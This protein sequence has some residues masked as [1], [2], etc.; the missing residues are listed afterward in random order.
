ADMGIHSFADVLLH[1]PYRYEDLNLTS[2]GLYHDQQRLVLQGKI[3]STPS[4]FRRGSM[5]MTR[6][7]FKDQH[8]HLMHV[9]AFNRPFLSK[10]I[11]PGDTMMVVG[12]YDASRQILNLIHAFKE[13]TSDSVKLKPIYRLPSTI[14]NFVFIRLVKKALSML[15]T[16]T[17]PQHLPEDILKAFSLPDKKQSLK[18]IHLPEHLHE[19]EA[20]MQIFKYEEAFQ[21]TKTMMAIRSENEATIKERMMPI[22]TGAVI[23]MMENLPYELTK[24]QMQAVNDILQDM[25]GKRRMYRL[26]QGDVGSGKTVVAALALYA[27]ALRK[28]QGALMAPTDSLAKQHFKTL[29]ELLGQRGLTIRL[30]VGSLPTAD[31]KAI[32]ESLLNGTIDIV[33]GTHA[34]FSSDTE[35]FSLGL[36]VI[37]EQHRFG[38]NQRDLLKDKGTQA[39]LL[40][41]SATPIP[42]SLAMTVYADM[43]IS[44]LTQFP[45][46]G[47]KVKTKIVE[48]GD[49]L[50]DYAIKAALEQQKRVYIIAPKIMESQSGKQSVI[51][52]YQQYAKRFPKQVTLLHGKLDAEDKEDALHAFTTGYT[53][54]IVS[55]TVIEVGIDVKAATLMI[56]H[57][58]DTF[59][60]ASLHQLRGRIGRDGSEAL[61]LLVVQDQALEG[62]ERLQVLV[63]SNDGFYIAEQD[64]QLRG[65]GE[66]MG[67]KQSGLPGF[68][69]LNIVKDQEILKNIKKAIHF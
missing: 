28:N 22:K 61:C 39:D 40:M 11:V 15:D 29:Q 35:F 12:K 50:I 52:L 2:N 4:I 23:D 10:M 43:D 5:V 26:L 69:Y 36:A 66:L 59:G 21:F 24:D 63:N 46:A 48:E 16:L 32:K 57:D 19:V 51:T 67:A 54:I 41:M 64:L 37:D 13:Q 62:L 18:T 55:T 17:F 9:I 31:K 25:N 27:N 68:Q 3:T 58:A 45:F 60:L 8:G 65:P 33:V 56:I 14:E 49:A 20:A 6:F 47:R 30:L 53:P 34:L 42:R 44:T 38:V 7:T 1:F